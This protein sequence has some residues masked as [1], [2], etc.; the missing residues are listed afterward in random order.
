MK[1]YRNT[2]HAETGASLGFSYHASKR[3]A[4][5]AAAESKANTKDNEGGDDRTGE[6]E[7]E[8]VDIKPTRAG[9]IHALNCYGAH[10]DNG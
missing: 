2:Y 8:R 7:T 4:L 1:I 6:V 5:K 10:N 9:I 3:A